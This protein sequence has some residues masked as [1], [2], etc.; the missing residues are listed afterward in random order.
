MLVSGEEGGLVRDA[1][2]CG[3]VILRHTVFVPHGGTSIAASVFALERHTGL[4]F[5]ASWRALFVRFF[6]QRPYS[7]QGIYGGG[8]VCQV[9]F[10]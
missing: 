8:V 4:P 6:L 10:L 3:L 5:S 7:I 9:Q 2:I 1:G